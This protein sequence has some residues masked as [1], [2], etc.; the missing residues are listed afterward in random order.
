MELDVEK[1]LKTSAR[2]IDAGDIPKY[3]AEILERSRLN[4]IRS[5]IIGVSFVI[6]LVA[7]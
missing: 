6:M 5:N 1:L 2:L 4:H 3:T 7:F